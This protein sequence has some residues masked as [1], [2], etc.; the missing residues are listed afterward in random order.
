MQITHSVIY[1]TKTINHAVY[2]TKII[3]DKGM[4]FDLSLI[5]K[6]N[7]F[8]EDKYFTLKLKANRRVIIF[9]SNI[10]LR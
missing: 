5:K 4:I 2:S 3:A 1:S 8:D 7:T 9:N 10:P 6:A